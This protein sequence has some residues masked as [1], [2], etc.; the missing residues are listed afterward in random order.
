MI[1]S[2][3]SLPSIPLSI[4][5][6]GCVSFLMKISSVI[7]YS[8]TP[9]FVT[10][11]L[12]AS[13][14]TLGFLEGFVEATTLF[15]RI[16]AGVLSDVIHKRKGIIAVGY[17]LILI[18]R[19]ILALTTS[20]SGVFIGRA[21]DRVGNGLDATPRDALVGDLAPPQIKGACYGLRESLSRTGSFSGSLLAIAL[22]WFTGNNYS[23]VFW[24]IS[25][26]TALA[27]ILLLML[28]KDPVSEK[29]Q[30]KK[31]KFK[32]KLSDIFNLSLSFWLTL[33]LSGFFMIS[34]FS[35]AFLILKAEQTGLDIHLIPLVMVIQNIATASTA[36]PVGYL[37]DKFGRRSMMA[38]GICLVILSDFLLANGGSTYI[39]LAGVFL[40]G[41]QMGI[42]Q[43]L[44]AIFLADSCPQDFR[45]TGFGLF[46]LINGLCLITANILSGWIWSEIGP[47]TMFYTS[48]FIAICSSV[49]LPFIHKRTYKTLAGS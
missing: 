4:W 20:M 44:L 17:V 14:L 8:L 1:K 38:L 19:P 7:V 37:S 31:I 16:F 3:Q 29:F 25:I 9:L 23:V 11:V 15:S 45:G 49:V 36:Y 41:A 10:Q 12:G 22:L 5:I 47:S 6:L 27:L 18:S 46:H 30:H 21:F 2:T 24:L 26:P 33:V 35:G 39:V 32:L 28:V 42:T 48:A 40:W 13:T 34:N 43:S